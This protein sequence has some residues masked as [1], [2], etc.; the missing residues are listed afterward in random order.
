MKSVT[1]VQDYWERHPLLSH[2]VG[3]ATA[4]ERWKYLDHIKRTDVETFAMEFWGFDEARQKNVLDI[5][6]GPGWLTVMYARKGAVVTAIDLTE[7]A[8]RLTAEALEAN[9]VSAKLEVASA[10]LLPFPEKTFDLVVSS[11]V[12]HHTPDFEAA[13]RESYRVTREG[14]TGLITL[15]RLGILHSRLAFPLV[16]A[17]MRLTKTRHPGADLGTNAA[18]VDE[19]VRQYDGEDNPV[20]IAKRECDWVNCLTTAGWRVVSVERHYF[21]ARMVPLLAH[22]P[23][24]LRWFLDR[25]FATMVYFT[26]QRV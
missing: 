6:C 26:L 7:H 20:G 17:V 1:D 12:L 23:L 21:P 14:G 22:A 5:G 19:F 4:D 18:S 13:I 25:Y 15:Y 24:W 3:E 8:V 11:G 16:R 10:E 2:E 9:R